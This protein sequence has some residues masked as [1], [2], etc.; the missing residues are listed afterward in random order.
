MPSNAQHSEAHAA[1][2]VPLWA[3]MRSDSTDSVR[4][5]FYQKQSL[6]PKSN[7]L[8]YQSRTTSTSTE[9]AV[10]DAD[11]TAK[12]GRGK[13]GGRRT[14]HRTKNSNSTGGP[15]E[16]VGHTRNGKIRIAGM[17]GPSNSPMDESLNRAESGE[18]GNRRDSSTFSGTSRDASV[19]STSLV[20]HESGETMR[21]R[22]FIQQSQ[23]SSQMF[24]PSNPIDAYYPPT[25]SPAN[26]VATR[27][28][29][30]SL[31]DSSVIDYYS[32]FS[33]D[34]LS[35]NSNNRTSSLYGANLMESFEYG[36]APYLS[37]D[38]QTFS[39]SSPPSP[40]RGS[41]EIDL[42]ISSRPSAPVSSPYQWLNSLSESSH[43]AEASGTASIEEMLWQEHFRAPAASNVNSSAPSHDLYIQNSSNGDNF[44][45]DSVYSSSRENDND[46]DDGA[47]NYWSPFTWWNPA[48]WLTRDVKVSPDGVPYF[49]VT[50][51][52]RP[53]AC[54]RHFFW[55]PLH[56]EFTALQ[57][58]VWAILIGAVMGV[59]TA[60][61]KWFIEYC[62]EQVWVTFPTHLL[63]WGVFTGI[64][65]R[66]PLY[67]YMWIC[68]AAMGGCISYIQTVLPVKI[69]DQNDWIRN[70]HTLGVQDHRTF[71][72]LFFISTAGMASGLS[73]G[74]ELPLVLTAGMFG[75]W[76]G[77]ICKQSILQA[78]VLNLTA[79]SAA[80]GGFFGFPMAGALFVLG[81][82]RHSPSE[83][84]YFLNTYLPVVSYS[85][86]DSA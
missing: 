9:K 40:A 26:D 69:P 14:R 61:W 65:G 22:N 23:A 15:M 30:S 54:I 47:A 10:E 56:P 50:S 41:R 11:V 71:C 20:S 32:M 83:F 78:R 33:G 37:A 12:H 6:P 13:V 51:P 73:L 80:V 4:G 39:A 79:A 81:E 67:H 76:L 45:S 35:L 84:Y 75:S 64:Q 86:R 55:D 25:D 66:F 2:D 53:S 31:R 43:G 34:R 19:L 74:P 36:G 85:R 63:Q 24:A 59:Y 17:A 28:T 60:L 1:E 38:H 44:G 16:S 82:S 46:S 52:W 29:S 57:L 3:R 5:A 49:E 77:I 27:S 68:P 18:A 21:R 8:Q 48:I 42:Q 72:S 58:F 62:I 70:L 7:I